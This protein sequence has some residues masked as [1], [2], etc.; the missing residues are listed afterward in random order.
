MRRALL[1]GVAAAGCVVALTTGCGEVEPTIP[2]DPTPP[3]STIETFSGI[4][5]I[6]GAITFPFSALGGSIT[7]TVA[8]LKPDGATIGVSI[9]VSSGATC[10]TA[11]SNDNAGIN[12]TVLG[13]VRD[14]GTLC[15]RVYDVGKLTEPAT[16]TINVEHQ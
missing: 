9:G 15:A 2:I 3:P 10:Q 16:F 1:K 8:E 13:V 5:T 7:A 12:S 6:N 14:S 4:L 11:L